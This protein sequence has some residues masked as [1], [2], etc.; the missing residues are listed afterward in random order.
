M[1]VLHAAVSS[2]LSQ[3]FCR[4]CC[5]RGVGITVESYQL[6]MPGMFVFSDR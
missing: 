1:N 2:Q 4:S 5:Y 3:L 6:T